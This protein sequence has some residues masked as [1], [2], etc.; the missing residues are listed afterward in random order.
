MALLPGVPGRRAVCRARPVSQ[1][2]GVLTLIGSCWPPVGL[3]RKGCARGLSRITA[4][5]GRG[6]KGRLRPRLACSGRSRACEGDRRPVPA[7]RRSRFGSPSALL[8][9]LLA[10]AAARA[11]AAHA[12]LARA[13]T[14]RLAAAPPPGPAP[15]R[16]GG[17]RRCVP[18]LRRAVAPR[19]RQ[20]VAGRALTDSP[21]RAPL[22][23]RAPCGHG[24]KAQGWP[25]PGR[26]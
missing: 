25:L 21:A 23:P 13:A 9:Q 4:R 10:A 7:L 17:S 18:S 1:G 2:A 14:E 5:F 24:R 16:G 8:R 3:R 19:R 11:G 12:S 15:R 26:C 22:R 20:A 6:K